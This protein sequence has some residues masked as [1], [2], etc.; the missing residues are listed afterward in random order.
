MYMNMYIFVQ[1]SVYSFIQK[2]I[3]FCYMSGTVLST[4]YLIVNKTNSVSVFIKTT[5]LLGR[6]KGKKD[7]YKYN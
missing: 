2:T 1:Q 4:G 6:Q 7:I 3:S 5:L